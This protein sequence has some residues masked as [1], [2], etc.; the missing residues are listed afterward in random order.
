[1]KTAIVTGATS[2][3]GLEIAK[4]LSESSYK[5]LGLG[6]DISKVS[7]ASDNLCLNSCDLLNCKEVKKFFSFSK[8]HFG[9]P[10]PDVLVLSAGIGHYGLHET[11]EESKITNLVNTNLTASMLFVSEYISYMKQRGSGHIVFI[12]SVTAEEVNPHGAAYGA[13]KAGLTSFA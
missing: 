1:M 12:S 4:K 7:F 10:A 6:R 5:V 11:I 2:G 8:D 3:I 13:A 9:T